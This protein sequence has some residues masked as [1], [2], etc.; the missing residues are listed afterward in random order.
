MTVQ[1]D[2][3][4][5]LLPLLAKWV[6]AGACGWPRP[7][8][9][10]DF[11]RNGHVAENN[12]MS[13]PWRQTMAAAFRQVTSVRGSRPGRWTCKPGWPLDEPVIVSAIFVFPRPAKCMFGFPATRDTGD[14]DKLMRNLLDA[15]GDANVYVDDSRV[16]GFRETFSMYTGAVFLEPGVSVQVY[17]A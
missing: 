5:P 9:S 12:N 2:Q 13:K 15:M 3:G 1:T 17:R 8:G 16:I 6:A 14:L 10:L 4:K 11:H 7:K